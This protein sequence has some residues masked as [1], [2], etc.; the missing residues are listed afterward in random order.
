MTAARARTIVLKNLVH[1]CEHML[2]D[3]N[4]H[5]VLS[6]HEKGEWVHTGREIRDRISNELWFA[7]WQQKKHGMGRD[8]LQQLIQPMAADD[9]LYRCG[10]EMRNIPLQSRDSA[11]A[12]LVLIELLYKLIEYHVYQN[13]STIYVPEWD[14]NG[15][16]RRQAS[17]MM[18]QES[19]NDLYRIFHQKPIVDRFLNMVSSMQT[20]AY[21]VCEYVI[22]VI[23][24][25]EKVLQQ[26]RE[27][28]SQ[29]GDNTG[30]KNMLAVIS[31]HVI[32]SLNSL[33]DTKQALLRSCIDILLNADI[34]V[35]TGLQYEASSILST[36]R[37][38]RSAEALLKA[39]TVFGLEHTNIR[40]N[41]IYALGTLRLAEAVDPLINVIQ[42]PEYTDVYLNS[43]G[44]G[45]KQTLNWE[46]REAI[47]SLGKCGAC[48]LRALDELSNRIESTDRE[49]CI[50]L[51][52][53]LTQIGKAQRKTYG[54]IDAGIMTL[55]MR[56]LTHRDP[57][58]FEEVVCGLRALELPDFLHTL[59][60]HN[61]GTIPVLALKPSS[62]GLYE[63]SET[64]LHL[65]SVKQPVVMAVTG[66]SGTGKT[67]FCDAIINGFGDIQNDD[68]IYLMR[69]NPRD[70]YVFNRMLGIRLL[71]ELRDPQQYED[72]PCSEEDDDPD[73]YFSD[74]IKTYARKKLIVL[75]GWMDRSYFYQVMKVFYMK[76][77]LDVM[78][79]FRTSYSTKRFNLEDRERVL[80]TVQTCLTYVEDPALEDTPFYRNGDVLVYNLDN[81]STS[82][83]QTDE[84]IEVFSRRKVGKWG[85]YIRIGS[86]D[87]IAQA[88]PVIEEQEAPRTEKTRSVTEPFK[89][90]K[91]Q[92]FAASE[93]HFTRVLNDD[94]RLPYLLET[95]QVPNIAIRKIVLYTHG[96]IACSGYD[97]T[98]GILSGL[99]D[100]IFYVPASS[101]GIPWLTIVGDKLFSVDD[102]DYVRLIS[103]DD[104]EIIELGQL[105]IP[106][107]AIASDRDHWVVTGHKDGSVML[108]DISSMKRTV[109]GDQSTPASAVAVDRTGRVFSGHDDGSLS[110][111]HQDRSQ[112][113]V[114]M[115]S[116]AVHLMDIYPGNRLVVGVCSAT[117][118]KSTIYLQRVDIARGVS[119]AVGPFDGRLTAMTAYFDGR[120]FAGV[121]T[122]GAHGSHAE[123]VV[124]DLK[125]SDANMA[126][127][128]IHG[129]QVRDC[130]VMGPRIITCGS[131]IH[132]KQ[133]MK[134][135]GTAL[136]VHTEREK[137]RL[138]TDAG[139]KPSFYRT[140]F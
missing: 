38:P 58:V 70:M 64:I 138:L 72:Y 26:V 37:D 105:D 52:W 6:L 114:C 134:I 66:D 44:I 104:L 23:S 119:T 43:G 111:V 75:D 102:N 7:V 65:V 11:G 22:H 24:E 9:E 84:I 27:I 78:V 35:A 47:W 15:A 77:Y 34:D 136:Y 50:A 117:G 31:E 103:F 123:V 8:C 132:D 128:G 140:L 41:V 71:K 112:A 133:D 32:L 29:R 45:Y 13:N 80:D 89:A 14:F 21:D 109:I 48:G 129:T 106:V 127:I 25:E 57:A 4:P 55:L 73:S 3:F 36:L 40:C 42:G 39:L 110:A 87:E 137:L 121:T 101:A 81:S 49:S 115:L 63:L 90:V 46:K 60:L 83:L 1:V 97:G 131:D 56:L 98:V 67:Y 124:C 5:T 61:I 74:F 10:L 107:S 51:A 28:I 125:S 92:T 20:T 33:T 96:Q 53:T 79:N 99:N 88:L 16:A 76:G 116:G 93:A 2:E 85:D 118:Q 18:K 126:C 69:D 130:I 59:Y 122:N 54:G 12:S 139:E 17:R 108:W 86:F 100:R 120:V 95:I 19:E 82:R 94:E 135:W 91:V 62:Q 113:R 30:K 68:I